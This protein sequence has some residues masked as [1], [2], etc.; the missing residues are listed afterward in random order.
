MSDLPSPKCAL[1]SPVAKMPIIKKSS[2]G[3]RLLQNVQKRQSTDLCSVSI[4]Q[5][6]KDPNFDG[7][8]VEEYGS[9]DGGNK[10]YK[11]HLENNHFLIIFRNSDP[12]QFDEDEDPFSGRKNTSPLNA[13]P[14]F[15]TENARSAAISANAAMHNQQHPS[16][17]PRKRPQPVQDTDAPKLKSSRGSSVSKAKRTRRGRKANEKDEEPCASSDCVPKKVHVLSKSKAIEWVVSTESLDKCHPF[18]V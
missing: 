5:L 17:R 14:F 6:V 16:R 8:L 12:F 18:S 13:R 9:G 1:G 15:A 2:T 4:H 10:R 11:P 7:F 3:S